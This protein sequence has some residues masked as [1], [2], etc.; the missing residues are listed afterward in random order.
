MKSTTISD[1]NVTSLDRTQIKP[2]TGISDEEREKISEGLK[3]IL[4]NSYALMLKTQNYHWNVRGHLF[5]PVH[6]LTEAQYEDLFQAIDVI[7]ERIRALGVL[8]P[9]SFEKYSNLSVL[10]KNN[11]EYSGEEMIADLVKGHETVI[12]ITR[13]LIP[14]AADT[15]DEATVDML[16]E[17]LEFHEKNS[18]ML[19]SFLES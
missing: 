15:V 4:A 14:L 17:R 5:K 10:D 8:A 12:K 19:R 2:Q 13:D 16:T 1:L 6:E 9:G 18:W 7:A 11:E 3:K